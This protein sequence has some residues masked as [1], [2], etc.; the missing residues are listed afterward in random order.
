[1]NY[2]RPCHKCSKPNDSWTY[3]CPKCWNEWHESPISK[4]W[5]KYFNDFN[6]DMHNIIWDK[7]IKGELK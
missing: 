2:T 6:T 7:W 3:L 1:M 4:I 5:L